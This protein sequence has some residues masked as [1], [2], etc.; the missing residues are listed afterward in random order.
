MLR[1]FVHL[2]VVAR[3]GVFTK[4][5]DGALVFHEG[6]APARHAIAGA[7]AGPPG[8][9][10]AARAGAVAPVAAGP[11][12]GK[13]VSLDEAQVPREQ[14]YLQAIRVCGQAPLDDERRRLRDLAEALRELELGHGLAHPP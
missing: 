2:H 1:C 9:A 4:A 10:A 8:A 3:G 13:D 11:S 7:A 12:T 5:E 6:P 14:A